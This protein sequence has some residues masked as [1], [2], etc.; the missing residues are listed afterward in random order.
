VRK[1]GIR[2]RED[3]KG[4]KREAREGNRERLIF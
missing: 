3:K 1:E 4:R 2:G